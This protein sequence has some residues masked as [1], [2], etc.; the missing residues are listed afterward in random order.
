MKIPPWYVITGGPSSGKTTIVNKLKA[1]GYYTTEETARILINKSLAKGI[2]LEDLRKDEASFQSRILEMK[3]RLERRLPCTKTI[4][5][6]RGVPDTIAYYRL[7]GFDVESVIEMSRN[8]YRRIFFLDQ[9]PFD[10]DYARIEDDATAK[11]I[12]NLILRA[13]KNLGYDVVRIPV[14]PV[15]E[16]ANLIL[17]KL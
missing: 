16:R 4:F 13:Y 5:L 14:M 1:L 6:D 11:K 7:F 10:S 8:R 17:S 15:G 3:L 12:S 2:T 9:L